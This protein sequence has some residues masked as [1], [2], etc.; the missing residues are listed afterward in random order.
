[1]TDPRAALV[2]AAHKL[3]ETG[4]L[5]ATD[6]NFSARTESNRFW[7]STSGAEKGQIAV[8]DF[9]LI[10]ASGQIV[11]GEGKPSSEWQMHSAIYEQRLEVNTILHAHP[12]NLTAFAAAHK[13]PDLAILAEAVLTISEIR[14]IPYAAPGTSELGRELA[15][16]ASRPGVYLLE[17]HGA[18]ALGSD[19]GDTLHRLERAEFLARVTLLAERI[20]GTVPLQGV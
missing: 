9:V 4:C 20:G 7:I 5:P 6:G 15:A 2:R 19:V 1:M 16:R 8:A 12:P 13:V 18:V 10:D 11:E 3:Y 14:L 17:N